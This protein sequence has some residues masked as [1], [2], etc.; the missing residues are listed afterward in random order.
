MPQ[1]GVF[2]KHEPGHLIGHTLLVENAM[3]PIPKK[4]RAAVIESFGGPEVLKVKE[5]PVP[6]LD[7]DEVLIAM[8]TA[9]VGSWDPDMR[10]GWSPSGRPRFPLVLG[11]DG[12]GT[13]AA[14]GKRVRRFAIGDRVYAYTFDNPK[15]GSYAQYVAVSAD[16]VGA[17]P[18]GLDMKQAG[19]LAISGLTALQGLEG[20]LHVRK[21]ERIIIT[22]A[23]GAVGSVAVQLAKARGARVFAIASG[24]DGVA[25]VRRLGADV[26]VDGNAEE[27]ERAVKRFAPDGANALLA[28]AGGKV[29]TAS[30]GALGKNGRVA[31]PNGVEPTPKKR[32]TKIVAYNGEGGT[33]ELA[34]L[35]RAVEKAHLKVPIGASFTLDEVAEAHQKVTE[36]VLGKVVLRIR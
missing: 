16:N 4:M 24:K 20:A 15:G 11:S 6:A 23:S 26:A 10:S 18:D 22:G 32:G 31:Y 25:L 21:G 30:L 1:A 2:S 29:L 35:N 36:H 33:R 5:I 3:N 7:D 34:D 8:H 12:S 27:I 17:V 13:V 14:K 9:G 28:F 19:G